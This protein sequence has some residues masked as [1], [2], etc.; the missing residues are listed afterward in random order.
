MKKHINLLVFVVAIISIISLSNRASAQTSTENMLIVFDASGSMIE[1]FGG[2]PRID[3]AKSAISDLLASLDA[4]TLVGLRALAEEKLATKT[5]ACVKTDL[6]QPFTSD[7]DAILTQ[8]NSLGAVGSYT[9]LAYTLQQSAGDFT[10]GANNVL[11]LLTDGLDTCGGN[12]AT[13]AAALKAAG[14]KVKTYV[15][16]L[17]ADAATR[18]QL[19]SIAAAGGGKYYDATDAASLATSFNAIQQAE[20][21]VDK[22]NT[23]S[24]LGKEVTGGNGYETAVAI[25][26]GMYHLSHHQLGGQYDY[27]KMNVNEGDVINYTLQSS[28][29]AVDYNAA[30]K[31]FTQSS[32]HNGDYS[33]M[34]VYSAT[35]AKLGSV[36]AYE[37]SQIEKDYINIDSPGVVYFLIGNS[38]T[39][40]TH[41]MSKS[42]IF[43]IKVTNPANQTPVA[44]TNN[45]NTETTPTDLSNSGS[46]TNQSGQNNQSVDQITSGVSNIFW[47]IVWVVV[48]AGILFVV[49][50][51][52]VIY[53]V[54]KRNKNK[55][56][57]PVQPVAP[58]TPNTPPKV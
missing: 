6:L 26:P 1:S 28:E 10:A 11:I 35:R 25:T 15:I 14:I 24:L 18:A 42:S 56:A 41:V 2:S 17:G 27:F 58:T 43:T 40:T 9:P 39:D 37:A 45:P 47:T 53:F 50:V 16:G 31:V 52:L 12:P 48:G 46:Q 23:D 33:G 29:S 32:R 51:A 19:S 13:A 57:N 21:P 7:R 8:V 49:I 34:R 22:T 30:T 55:V 5:D 44:T 36:Y 3:V 20:H 4:N 54:V 38:E